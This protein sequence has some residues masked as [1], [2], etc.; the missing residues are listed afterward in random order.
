ML[1]GSRGKIEAVQKVVETSQ[2]ERK[3]FQEMLGVIQKKIRDNEN[4][5]GAMIKAARK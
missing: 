4:V 5:L 1:H 3:A 2:E